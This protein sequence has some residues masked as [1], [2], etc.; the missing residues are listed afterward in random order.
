MAHEPTHRG[1]IAVLIP[2]YNDAGQLAMTLRSLCGQR[3]PLTAVV[4]DDGSE[5]PLA[6][7]WTEL[8]FPVVLLRQPVNGG[9]ER[10]LNAGLDYITAHGFEYVARLDNGDLCAPGRLARQREFLDANPDVHLVGSNV[11]WRTDDGQRRFTLALPTTHEAIVRALHHT[12]CLI[13][14]TVMF[15]TTVVE[16]VGVY[17][18]AYPAAEDYEFFWRV[19]K[20]F[21]VANIPETLL[22]TRFDPE[23]ISIRRRGRQLRSKL[24]I[25]LEFFRA[26][27]PLSYIGIAKTLALLLTPYALVVQLK[28]LLSPSSAR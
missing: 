1:R 28:R 12:V 16:E 7:D 4:V 6:N 8:D 5:P 26:G 10:A 20:R 11:E 17:S 21:R 15:R 22:T 19:A 9:I 3:P 27:E 25:Q 18:T 13:H 24:R 2:V 23:G 14:P